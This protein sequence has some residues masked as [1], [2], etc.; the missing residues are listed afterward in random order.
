V[1]SLEGEGVEDRRGNGEGLVSIFKLHG[2]GLVVGPA[3][4]GWVDAGWVK[5]ELDFWQKHSPNCGV[6]S[7]SNFLV[8]IQP[9]RCVWRE[10]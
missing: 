9:Y 5:K 3:G 1:A 6:Y 10:G 2:C 4:M 7:R 8:T